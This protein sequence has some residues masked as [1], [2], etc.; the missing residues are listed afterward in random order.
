MA[1]LRVLLV[2]DSEDD[3]LLLAESLREG[4]FAVDARR[5]E[6]EE[7]FRA[8]LREETWD[9]VIADYVLPRFSGIAAVR[10]VRRVIPD[11]PVIMVS[12]KGGEEHAVE[13]MRAGADDYLLKESLVRLAPAVERELRDMQVRR[14]RRQAIEELRL[15]S[16]A[17]ES[18]A[19]GVVITKGD[20]TIIWVNPAVTRLTGYTREEMIGQNPHIFKSGKQPPALYRELW[21][22][23][24]R[25]EVWHGQLVNRR[26]DGTLY[27]EE[28]T[29][30]PVRAGS[31]DITHF[32][33]IKEDI[34]ERKHAEEEL[35]E[36]EARFRQLADAMPQLVW[37]AEPDGTVDYYN[38]RY[39]EYEGITSTGE[40]GYRWAPVLHPD[41][42]QPTVAAWERA[43]ARG[44]VYQVEH[45]ARMTDG[46]YRWHLSR[47]VPVRDEQGLIVKWYGTATDIHDLKAAQEES[48]RLQEQQQ[49]MMRTIS[50]DLRAP[51]AIIYGHMQ[52]LSES[53]DQ[54][55]HT[56]QERDSVRAVGSAVQRMNAMIRD[57]VDAVRL[58]GGQLR[59]EPHPVKLRAYLDA[60][61]QRSAMVM[62]VGR[63]R[64]DIPEDLPPAYAD[65]NRLE[66]IFINLLSNALKYSAPDAPVIIR[67]RHAD[68][69][70]EVSVSDQ[71]QGIAPED[72][73]R[74]FERFYRA[75]GEGETEGIGLGLYITKMLV[76]AHGGVVWAE[77]EV[78]RGSTFYFTLPVA[79]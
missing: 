51:L 42:M 36:S 63:I 10:I 45:R 7:D 19:N 53:I 1:P 27:T 73:P 2:E 25:G 54:H 21:T 79:G 11:L 41:D 49:D 43:L 28:M 58:E 65:H 69:A 32:V 34:S 46:N 35:R 70:I 5:V 8:A 75:K 59:L 52:L 3:A 18:A 4:G 68:D 13:A 55:P 12:G 77:S 78:G 31:G 40:E 16:A 57:L 17:L 72:L 29:V 56:E 47:G 22:T 26:K 64:A 14:E 71:G 44:D 24:R 67:A 38:V 60:L 66:R 50:H 15:L 61:L 33:A 20:G 9:L 6:T 48:E 39:K 62:D 30:T 23:I 76:E 74:L 37:T